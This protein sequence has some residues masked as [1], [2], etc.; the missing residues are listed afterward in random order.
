MGFWTLSVIGLFDDFCIKRSAVRLTALFRDLMRK[1]LLDFGTDCS[2]DFPPGNPE[3]NT[4]A[5]LSTAGIFRILES[6]YLTENNWSGRED[7]NLRP[8]GPE[9][10]TNAY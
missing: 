8:P 2:K 9:P 7:L 5:F 3:V 4:V 10:D 1:L 6:A